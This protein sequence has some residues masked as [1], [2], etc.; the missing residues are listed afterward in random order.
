MGGKKNLWNNF[1]HSN[2]S[3]IWMPE[4]E[5][6]EEIE[7]LFEQIMRENFP[8]LVKEIDFQ[9]SRKL[10]ESQRCWTQGGTYQ[11]TS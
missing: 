4:E 3:T 11:D 8:N 10:R 2:I 6:E 9:D 5:K 1:K 7:N